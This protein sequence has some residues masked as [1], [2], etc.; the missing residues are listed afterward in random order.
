VEIEA[1]DPPLPRDVIAVEMIM[2][3]LALKEIITRIA[4]ATVTA[5]DIE[6]QGLTAINPTD[7]TIAGTE[8]VTAV[9]V[10]IGAVIAEGDETMTVIGIRDVVIVAIRYE[11]P[12][13][14]STKQHK[15]IPSFLNVN[16]KVQTCYSWST[17]CHGRNWASEEKKYILN[18]TNL[19]YK[20]NEKERKIKGNVL[21]LRNGT[22]E[23]AVVETTVRETRDH[24]LRDAECAVQDDN[25]DQGQRR[26]MTRPMVGAAVAAV[27]QGR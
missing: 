21:R 13:F 14:N 10:E 23:G 9:A 1:L 19:Q 3:A 24:I 2:V 15:Y 26:R 22:I 4:G 11:L 6:T 25:P 20:T 16:C 12:F 18:Y 27:T 5:V 7:G 8:T 17:T